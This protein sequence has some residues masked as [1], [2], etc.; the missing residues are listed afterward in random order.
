MTM[1]PMGSLNF[2]QRKKNIERINIDNMNLLHQLKKVKPT[3]KRIDWYA[4]ESKVN[5]YKYN[6]AT[7]HVMDD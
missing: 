7:P 1:P 4:H 3:Y 6:I 5:A 2:L